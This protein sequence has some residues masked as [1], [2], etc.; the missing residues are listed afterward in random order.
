MTTV[1][2]TGASSPVGR[3]LLERLD[4]DEG[5]T[6]IIGVDVDEP[7]MPVAK[8]E[9]R[10]ADLRDRFLAVLLDGADVIVHL[11]LDTQPA[12]DEDTLFARNTQG[13]RN[14]L[15]AASK[16]GARK[17]VHLSDGTAYG[18]HP[19]NPVP[20]VEDAPL[21]ANPDYAPAYHALLAEE[22]VAEFADGH[23]ETQVA[24]L[25]PAIVLGF[26][27]QSVFAQ[28]LEHPRVLRIHGHEPPLQVVH[29][30]DLGA[31]L[32]LAA[33][34]GLVGPYNVAAEGWLSGDEV[35]AVLGKRSLEVPETVAFSVARTLWSRGL[36][37]VPPGML[38]FLMHPRV[39]SAARLRAAGWAPTRSNR[40]V[41]REFLAEHAG[42]V[43]LGPLRVRR[44]DLYAGGAT[45]GLLAGSVL[46][47]R[48]A[49]R[50]RGQGA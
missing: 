17:V 9:F 15:V 45:V 4:A 32:H 29:V 10:G 2:V 24:V 47:G 6:R 34:T 22:L 18:A 7:Q 44:R 30:D 16:V 28:H 48:I 42:Y 12:R 5:V 40:E 41:L 13:T 46:A 33:T 23:P 20:L 11:G 3:A 25:R 43:R 8:L 19:D 37:A 14:V 1:A 21:R 50:V 39:L 49:R 36:W 26:R 31:A 27:A 38:H 35:R